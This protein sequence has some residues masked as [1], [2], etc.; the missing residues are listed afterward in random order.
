MG[1]PNAPEP[2]RPETP[3]WRRYLRFLGPDV[4]A[5]VDDE[6]HFHLT[7]RA[8]AL[9]AAGMDPA[10]ARAE[11]AR[12]MGD[13]EGVRRELRR[14]GRRS[15]HS[16]RVRERVAALGR[17]ARLAARSLRRAPGFTAIAVLTLALGTGAATAVFTLLDR[18]A[19]RPLAYPAAERLVHVDH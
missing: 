3:M 17:D 4:D 8:E 10:A 5:D 12:R 7:A 13:V 14:I 15:E 11:A 19:L 9:M 2:R 18:V 6:L 1:A 16:R